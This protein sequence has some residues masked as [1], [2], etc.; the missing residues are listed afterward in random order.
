MTGVTKFVLAIVILTV[1]LPSSFAQHALDSPSDGRSMMVNVLD[2]QGN[3]VRNLSKEN[4]HLRVNGKPVVVLDARY[5]LAPRRIVVLLDMSGSMGS[6]DAPAGKWRIAQEAAENLLTETPDD[7]PIAMLTFSSKV[8]NVF[9]FS[10]RRAAIANWLKE[11]ASPQ[12]KRKYPVQT[13]LFDAVFEALKLLQPF[14]PGD[15]VYAITDGGDNASQA[16]ATKTKL[17]LLQSGVRLFGFLFVEPS[18]PPYSGSQKEQDGTVS[19]LS[20]VNDTGGYMFGVPGRWRVPS[21]PPG[22]VYDD[23]DNPAKIKVFTQR[24]NIQVSGF[25]TL[26]L[27]DIPSNARRMKLDVVSKEGK[28]GKDIWVTYS[29]ALLAVR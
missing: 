4:F 24:L 11:S 3:A 18:R 21:W 2:A 27:G 23:D 14:Q 12:R 19:F 13:A 25:W 10:Q 7:V 5:S 28:I 1:F 6:E 16:S 20:I 8:L 26:E 22:Y 17:A 15:A 9:D 29:R